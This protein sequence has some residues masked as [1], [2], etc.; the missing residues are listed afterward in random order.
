LFVNDNG[1]YDTGKGFKQSDGDQKPRKKLEVGHRERNNGS[2]D[3][4]I[5]KEAFQKNKGR[6]ETVKGQ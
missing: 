1:T 4:R 6:G 2:F 5:K 3:G